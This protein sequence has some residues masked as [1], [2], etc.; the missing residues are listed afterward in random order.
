MSRKVFVIPDVHVP[1]HDKKAWGLTLEVI[2]DLKPDVVV[3]IGDFADFY[4]VSSFDKDPSRRLNL[5]WE[6]DC[7]NKELDRLCQVAKNSQVVF[8][9][10]NHEDRLR[11]Y[12]WKKAQEL[13]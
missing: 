9:E 10:G 5:K 11:R 7:I 1:Y 12:L 8:L 4:A 13:Y 3:S 2:K 6:V